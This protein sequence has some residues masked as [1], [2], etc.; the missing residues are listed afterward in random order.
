MAIESTQ[1]SERRRRR[2]RSC[3][4]IGLI[5]AVGLVSGCAAPIG[6]KHI[7]PR[8]AQRNLTENAVSSGKLSEKA[9][10]V[11]RRTGHEDLWKE[12]PAAVLADLHTL[13]TQ[14]LSDFDRELS[15]SVLDSVA[16]LAFA[17][18][19]RSGDSPYY[20]AAAL[21]AWIY[22]FPDDQDYAPSPMDRG[23][24]LAADIYNRS[25]ALALFDRET[26]EVLLEDHV[27]PLPFGTLELDFDEFGL[28]MGT[29][30]LSRFISLAD[31]E[32]RG[33]N[34]R[35]RRSGLGAPLAARISSGEGDTSGGVLFDKVRV[36]VTAL[37]HFED[38]RTGVATGR[39]TATLSVETFAGEEEVSIQGYTIPLEAEPSAA[40]ALQLTESP[41]WRR[42]LAGFFQ[43]DLAT[44]E[45]GLVSLTP[46]QPGRLPVVL[47]H[48]TAS[49]AGRWADLVNDLSS[50]PVLRRYFQVYLFTYNTGNPIVYSGWLLRKAL[51]DLVADLDPDGNDPSL[52][53]FVVIGHSQGGLLAKLLAVDAGEEFWD[54]VIDES[55]DQVVLEPENREL[56]EGSLLVRP[57]PYV[58]RVVFLSTPHRGSRLANLGPAR[59]L[60]RAVRAPANLVSAAGDLFKED[61]DAEVQRRLERSEGSIG[62]MSPGSTFI[63]TLAPLPIDSGISAHSIIGVK[64]LEEP[65]EKAG[66]GIVAYS[67]AH[68]DD[69]ESELVVES[70]HSSQA[71]PFV[72]GEARRILIEHLNE[73]IEKGLVR[74][75]R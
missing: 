53:N 39:Y 24:R 56:L 22:L 52:R 12:D 62:N 16:E 27:H 36:P 60:G 63:Q 13:L 17:H 64:N 48:G 33:L 37:L 18:A 47:V 7:S 1:C 49:S 31:L 55:P 74:L 41:P 54:L 75:P 32:V 15:T 43:G 61:A 68:L 34:N 9:K 28:R 11:L 72:V 10:T 65:R 5:L 45:L 67:S 73:A 58:T 38:L 66:D 8:A 59:L 35:Y 69:V 29:R 57:S 3:A 51:A 40:L 46:Y 4:W 44:G 20:L 19:A 42:E 2:T 50:D 30:E 14:P 71:N 70:G 26:G 23:V 25:L 6:V 21:Y